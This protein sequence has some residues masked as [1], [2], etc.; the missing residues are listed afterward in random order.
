MTKNSTL[1]HCWANEMSEKASAAKV[2]KMG[3]M[4]NDADVLP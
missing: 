1:V 4:R 2:N 3:F